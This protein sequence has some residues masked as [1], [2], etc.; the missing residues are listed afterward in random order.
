MNSSNNTD[1]LLYARE[2]L[3]TGEYVMRFQCKNIEVGDNLFS[4]T[5]R[6]APNYLAKLE[7]TK[8]VSIDRNT[9]TYPDKPLFVAKFK[10]VDFEGLTRKASYTP[11]PFFG[12]I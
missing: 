11:V 9:K 3:G 8:I 1:V 10:D 7:C 12:K 5:A 2:Y 4:H 6:H